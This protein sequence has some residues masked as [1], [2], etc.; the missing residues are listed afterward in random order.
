MHPL[1]PDLSQLTDTELETKVNDLSKRL[2]QA[3]T[4]GPVT[5]AG[6]LRMML[7]DYQYELSRRR[8]AQLNELISKNK[9]FKDI[10]DIS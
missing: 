5:A 3:L 10:I 9:N 1:T 2:S 6:Q 4:F 8:D 7:D